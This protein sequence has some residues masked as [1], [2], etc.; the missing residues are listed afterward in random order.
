MIPLVSSS[1]IRGNRL[2]DMESSDY[3]RIQVETAEI[4]RLT[5]IHR[6]DYLFGGKRKH[7][8][9]ANDLPL[10]YVLSTSDGRLES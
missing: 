9:C 10:F 5:D 2:A 3:I 4:K 6:K 1:E 8:A 7:G